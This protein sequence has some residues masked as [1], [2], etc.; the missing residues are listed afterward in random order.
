M[1]CARAC[2]ACVARAGCVRYDACTVRADKCVCVRAC[3]ACVQCSTI[4]AC[5]ACVRTC[6]QCVRCVQCVHAAAMHYVAIK[7]SMQCVPVHAACRHAYV[8]A[9]VRNACVLPPTASAA[10]RG[11]RRKTHAYSLLKTVGGHLSALLA[12][13]GWV[14]TGS[15][16]AAGGL[17]ILRALLR[18][19]CVFV[20]TC[21]QARAHNSELST[22][23]DCALPYAAVRCTT[24][25][26]CYINPLFPHR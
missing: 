6:M 22:R 10:C 24:N 25:T 21:P 19:R 26:H 7:R 4:R 8:R 9:Y 18:L 5:N 14:I 13:K 16:G 1:H 15:D 20:H 11:H 3:D 23:N 12:G 2:G 17:V